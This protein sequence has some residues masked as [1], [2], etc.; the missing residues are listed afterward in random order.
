MREFVDSSGVACLQ[1]GQNL[2]GRYLTERP[3]DL[4]RVQSATSIQNYKRVFEG[5]A[6]GLLSRESSVDSNIPSEQVPLNRSYS[7][8]AQADQGGLI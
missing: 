2:E 3:K 5:T 7:T 4:H 8:L 1:Q 6:G